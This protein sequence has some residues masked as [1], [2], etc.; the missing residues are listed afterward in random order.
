MYSHHH[1]RPSDSVIADVASSLSLLPLTETVVLISSFSFVSRACTREEIPPYDWHRRLAADRT[2]NEDGVKALLL[3]TPLLEDAAARHS[4]AENADGV[5]F[6]I[7]YGSDIMIYLFD[8]R[9][10]LFDGRSCS[11]HR[12]GRASSRRAK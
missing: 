11:L 1:G 6:M 2:T 12:H 10:C 7:A 3:Q 5:I 8:G 9:S 4:T